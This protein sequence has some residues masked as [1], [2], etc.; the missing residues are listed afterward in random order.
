MAYS[1]IISRL[2]P[3]NNSVLGY[4]G[5]ADLVRMEKIN[6]EY[7]ATTTTFMRRA[8]NIDRQLIGFLP[9]PHSF[10]RMQSKTGTVISG[11]FALQFFTRVYYPET[12]LD[13]FVGSLYRE[14]VGGWLSS[15]GFIYTPFTKTHDKVTTTQALSYEDAM[16]CPGFRELKL[17][18]VMDVL[19]FVRDVGGAKRRVV[20]HVTRNSPIQ[21][22]LLFPFSEFIVAILILSHFF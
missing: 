4:L 2:Y 10:R 9:D 7:R 6:K 21:T 12:A 5:P 1:N 11:S 14:E 15:N 19:D 18:D 3:V 22:I 20:L 8:Y 16:L 13:I 17:V